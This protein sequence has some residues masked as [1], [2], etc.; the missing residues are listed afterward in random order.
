M[1]SAAPYAVDRAIQQG[2]DAARVARKDADAPYDDRH[3]MFR[4]WWSAVVAKSDCRDLTDARIREHVI[5]ECT[6]KS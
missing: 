5:R 6:R 3:P 1:S 2:I 4:Y